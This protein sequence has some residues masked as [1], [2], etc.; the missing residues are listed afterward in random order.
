[1]ALRSNWVVNKEEV[2]ADN[3]VVATKHPLASEA[4]VEILRRGGNAIDAAVATGFAICV[5][6]PMMT[7]ISGVGFMVIHLADQ[8]KQV[9]M[10]YPPR[11]PKAARP[12]M[13]RTTGQAGSGIRIYEVEGDENAE[14]Y[15]SIAVPG[16][17]AGLCL[18]HKLF[19]KLPL[20]QVMEPAIALA[21][22]G[23]EISW[24]TSLSIGSAMDTFQRFPSSAAVFLPDGWPPKHTPAPAEK[25]VQK[26]LARVLRLI[27]EHGPDA[28][29][30]G[31]VA[32]AIERDMKANGGLITQEDLG[33]YQAVAREPARIRYRDYEVLTADV[34]YGGTTLLQTLNIL[35]NFELGSLGH[36]SREYLHLFIEAARHA[37]ADRYHYLGDPDFVDVPMKGI[38]SKDYARKLASAI[39]GTQARLEDLK[40]SEP[41]MHYSTQALHDPWEF[42]GRPRP[43]TAYVASNPSD[44]DCTTHFGVVDKDRNLV[45]CT[46]TAVSLFGSKV[47][48]PGLGILWNNGMVWFNPKP[49][50]ANSIAPWKRPLTNMAPLIALRDG[51]PYLSIG[52]P[53][54]RHIINCNTQ[55]FLNV[56][57]FGMGIQDAIAQPRLDASAGVT[58]V[59][60]RFDNASIEALAAMGHNL[61][62][63]EETAADANFATPLGILVDHETGKVH[64]GVDVFRIAEARG[65]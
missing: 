55:V 62:I 28:F 50:A 33:S 31:E 34:H 25:L 51:K 1:M 4:G 12:D 9:V 29:Y 27:A 18:A 15:R 65:Y 24:F 14:G 2:V 7:C 60:S 21:E 5:V 58:L 39:S 38:L 3:G 37:F 48:T 17:V 43:S 32:A 19:G 45:S 10:E 41:W 22:D 56:V 13:Y 44:G 35:E 6:E 20:Q 40:D 47:V 23:F 30:K 52:S 49:G 63:A 36:N 8:D 53:G 42:E 16:T 57:E 54:G 59:D 26:D 46:Q 61:D 64:G 11:A